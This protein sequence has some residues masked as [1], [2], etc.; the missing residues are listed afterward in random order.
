MYQK[1]TALTRLA[2]QK[3][4]E[5]QP[6][7]GGGERGGYI[8]NKQTRNNGLNV[9]HKLIKNKSTRKQCPKEDQAEE[10]KEE[11]E[12]E[13]E[14]EDTFITKN[15]VSQFLFYC[16]HEHD[17]PPENIPEDAVYFRFVSD[18]ETKHK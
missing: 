2:K 3:Y 18:Q 11:E 8:D 4:Q 7:G 16:R 10:E 6:K 5:I 1:Q 14:E 9:K 13:K 12:I 15:K 17:N